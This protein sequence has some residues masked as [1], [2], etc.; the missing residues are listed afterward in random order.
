[1]QELYRMRGWTEGEKMVRQSGKKYARLIW[2]WRILFFRLTPNVRETALWQYGDGLK[3]YTPPVFISNELVHANAHFTTCG[4]I[5]FD[6]LP[7]ECGKPNEQFTIS[8]EMGCK[9]TSPSWGWWFGLLY[10]R[11]CLEI[12]IFSHGSPK[13]FFRRLRNQCYIWNVLS[14]RHKNHQ[15]SLMG[16]I[17]FC[18]RG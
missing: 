7:Y 10:Q 16:V 6:P 17:P 15:N 8:P 4:K 9:K 2:F 13:C 14:R 1:M 11:I 12:S 3:C 5:D 18:D